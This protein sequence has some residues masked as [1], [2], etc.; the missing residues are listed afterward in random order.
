MKISYRLARKI[1]VLK[2]GQQRSHVSVARK[3]APLP[4][5]V[6]HGNL[7]DAADHRVFGGRNAVGRHVMRV[8]VQGGED[9]RQT[10]AVHLSR[11]SMEL[12]LKKRE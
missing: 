9:R 11:G 1:V 5:L 4:R 10:E 7:F 3:L 8:A 6:L 2:L 12:R